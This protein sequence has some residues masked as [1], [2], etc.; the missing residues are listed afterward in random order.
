[1]F[2]IFKAYKIPKFVKRAD[3]IFT[4]A[5]DSINLW[6]RR[7]CSGG[8]IL[9]PVLST[10]AAPLNILLVHTR[11]PPPNGTTQDMSHSRMD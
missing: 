7:W 5:G 6:G 4:K 10:A 9:C 11:L 1:M 8:R 2:V 3:N